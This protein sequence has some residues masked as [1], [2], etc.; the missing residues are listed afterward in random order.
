MPSLPD[1]LLSIRRPDD[2][3]AALAST[4]EA[5]ISSRSGL[6]GLAMKTGFSTLR[7]AKP[8]IANRAVRALLPEIGKALDPLYAEFGKSASTDFGEYLGQHRERAAALVIAAVDARLEQ[9]SNAPAKAIY[10]R[11]RGSAGEELQQLLPS[12]GRVLST[13]II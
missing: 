1:I 5:H 13:H 4:L 2:L 8:D 6:K 11:F 7:S 3:V 9:A 10:K 12:L